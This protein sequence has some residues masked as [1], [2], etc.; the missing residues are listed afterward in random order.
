MDDPINLNADKGN[1]HGLYVSTDSSDLTSF[2]S[3][4]SHYFSIPVNKG[5]SDAE[6]L[7]YPK[8]L[9]RLAPLVGA[10]S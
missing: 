1:S 9:W 10:M 3:A 5:Q 4:L 6:A 8:I 2:Y 7:V